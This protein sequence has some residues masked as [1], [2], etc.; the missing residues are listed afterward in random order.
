[1]SQPKLPHR[2]SDDGGMP[3]ELVWEGVLSDGTPGG[4]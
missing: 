2:S 3:D 4:V 1:M